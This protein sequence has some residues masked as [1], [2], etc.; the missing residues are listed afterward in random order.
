MAVGPEHPAYPSLFDEKGKAF[1]TR[2]SGLLD[3]TKVEI[4]DRVDHFSQHGM[5]VR[6]SFRVNPFRA[7][8]DFV[9][10]MEGGVEEEHPGGAA[11]DD[12]REW[13]RHLPHVDP[14]TH[15]VWT[16][17]IVTPLDSDGVGASPAFDWEQ[18]K[19]EK[20]AAQQLQELLKEIDRGT[21]TEQFY[22]GAIVTGIYRPLV[23][24][25]TLTETLE[26]RLLHG[27]DYL[28]P[29]YT[30]GSFTIPW[31]DGLRWTVFKF[32]DKQWQD[33]D[34]D[35]IAPIVIPT[36][37][38]TIRRTLVPELHPEIWDK[39]VGH[40][41]YN[42]WGPRNT[43]WFNKFQAETLRFESW[44]PTLKQT[45]TVLSDDGTRFQHY[46]D[47]ELK[48]TQINHWD[49]R[50]QRSDGIFRTNDWVTWQHVLMKPR[51]WEF[52]IIPAL[53]KEDVSWFRPVKVADVFAQT[54]LEPFFGDVPETGFL[55]PTVRTFDPLFDLNP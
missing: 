9:A 15:T 3:I 1:P 27:M 6:R 38:I 18:A 7:F 45:R 55:Y 29:T 19:K 36:T 25:S 52:G 21:K 30:P 35:V 46:W 41:C 13:V 32:V 37:E 53:N 8:I 14:Y 24:I 44:T 20:P 16:D 34:E 17:S 51:R 2:G 50:V 31:V 11:P 5:E 4:R 28:D 43:Q 12:A 54:L 22:P 33:I 39:F 42:T 40:L 48:F 23:T 10:T 47:I 49:H 26:A